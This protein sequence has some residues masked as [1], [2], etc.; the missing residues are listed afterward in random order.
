MSSADDFLVDDEGQVF[1]AASLAERLG[2]GKSGKIDD[3]LIQH[4]VREL[5]Y[6]HVA[7][8]SDGLSVE[9]R[10]GAFSLV[11]LIGA[12]FAVTDR[13]PSHIL[14]T[15]YRDEGQGSTESFTSIGAFANRA[16]I[17]AQ[18]PSAIAS[19]GFG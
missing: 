2:R 19:S 11:T 6:I 3:A 15:V 18:S 1:P 4:A 7:N 16:E 9:L 5:G 13:K 17:L 12:L 14:L 8:G 10:A